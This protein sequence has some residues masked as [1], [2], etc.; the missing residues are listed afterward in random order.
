MINR[1]GTKLEKESAGQRVIRKARKSDSKKKKNE[2]PRMRRLKI[3]ATPQE[4][5]IFGRVMMKHG[6]K[7][8]SRERT[9]HAEQANHLCS[10]NMITD[11]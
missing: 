6:Q 9:K 2:S 3:L 8:C 7:K 10:V 5:S 1:C 11:R 4:L